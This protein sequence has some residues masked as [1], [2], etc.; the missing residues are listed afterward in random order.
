MIH[1]DSLTRKL[2]AQDASMYQ[3]LPRGVVFPS[4][5]DD[6]RNLVKQAQQQRVSIVPRS[7][8]TSLAG[9]TTG[10]GIVIDVSR[11]MTRILSIDKKSR[12]AHV[13][14]GVIRDSLN[15]SADPLGLMFGPDTSTTNRCMIGGMIG[16]NSSG[17][18]SI[19]HGTT[20]EHVHEME[21]V[22]SDG[23]VAV[24]RP[25]TLAELEEKKKL[26]NLEGHI[27][28]AMIQLLE[29]NQDLIK[30][31]YPHPEIIRRNTGYALDKLL[32]MQP[33]NTE[34]RLFNLCELLC[35]SEGT[36]ALT[37]SAKVNLVP[38]DP[39]RVMLV[40]QFKSLEEAM[41]ATVEA[42]K[43]AP[44]A[45]ELVD[46]VILDATKHNLEQRKNRFFLD[47]EPH[48]M[49]IIQFEGQEAQKLQDKAEQLVSALQAQQLGYAFPVFTKEEQLDAVWALRKAGLGL[50]MGLDKDSRSPTFCED[51][52]VRVQD[53]P[54]YVSDFKKILHRYNTSCVFYA[55]ASV[56]ELHLRPMIDITR[57][58]GVDTMKAMAEEIARLVKAYGGSLSGEHGDG[59]ARA[60]YIKYV[61]GEEII[62][63]L[64]QVKE[65]WD[66]DGL[67]NPG[68]VVSPK[69]IEEDL[70]FSPAYKP[71]QVDTVFNWREEGGFNQALDLCNGA[72]VCRKL[73]ESGG[74]MCPSYQATREEKDSTRGRAN[75]FRQVFEGKNPETFSSSDL[76]EALDVC[77]SCKA[78]K[79]E[80]PANVDMAKM[81]AEFL[82]GWYKQQPASAGDRFF[83]QSPALFALASVFPALSNWLIQQNGI[84]NLLERFFGIDKR[85]TLPLVASTSFR[86][87]VKHH[88]SGLPADAPDVVLFV[89][90]FLDYIEPHIPMYA[91]KVLNRLGFEVIVSR[92][93]RSGRAELSKGFLDEARL[94]MNQGLDEFVPYA[95]QGIPIIGLEPSE[96]LTLR[97]EWLDICDDDRLEDA[98]LVASQSFLLEE[99]VVKHMP[100]WATTTSPRSRVVIHEHCHTKA[101]TDSTATMNALKGLGYTVSLLDT[102]CCGMAG[103]F[104]YEKKHYDVSRDIASLTLLPAVEALNEE[105]VLCSPGLSCRHQVKDLGNYTA[106]HPV[107]LMVRALDL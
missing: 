40:A 69:G 80:C 39:H 2:Y 102:G 38:V 95:S 104:G 103:S 97:D 34:G 90:T 86:S 84:K 16:N 22:L 4:S 60:P 13:Q 50:L 96:V 46:E 49:L 64:R 14:P 56:G 21:V 32:E 59:R 23:S 48:C 67:F 79:S 51:T 47:G 29:R 35:G 53:L 15:R 70:R 87:W 99:F 71:A 17:S 75:I 30:S 105:V 41:Q 43:H 62:P 92:L 73:A 78:C 106:F 65:A 82:N 3:E 6:I 76:K 5:V 61:L 28:R 58:E 31:S 83:V 66:P 37:V 24:F 91:V 9:Q 100:E 45:V 7:A 74:T 94:L 77:L 101:L 68:K 42:V 10:N 27:Y 63:V 81:K 85:R 36:L 19:K 20:R 8:G 89:D 55:H 11:Y 52:A 25:L 44:A 93:T 33:F 54:D 72:G 1:V 12:V 98:H 88:Q 18:F 107:E 57:Q 26:D